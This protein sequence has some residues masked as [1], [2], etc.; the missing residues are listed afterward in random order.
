M[1]TTLDILTQARALYASAPSHAARLDYPEPGT[2]CALTALW[3]A[4]GSTLPGSPAERFLSEA[5][6]IHS[7]AIVEWN[8]T[9]STETVLAAFDRAIEAAA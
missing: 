4:S 5:A 3:E 9:S 1:P 6:G 2:H 8:A 7:R